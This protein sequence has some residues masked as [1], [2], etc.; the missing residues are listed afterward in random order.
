MDGKRMGGIGRLDPGD[1]GADSIGGGLGCANSGPGVDGNDHID[2]IR[3]LVG[4]VVHI[5]YAQGLS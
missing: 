2:G 1:G 4:G 5:D 3:F